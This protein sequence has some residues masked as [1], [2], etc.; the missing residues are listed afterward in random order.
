ME[1]MKLIFVA[2]K[3][4]LAYFISSAFTGLVRRMGAESG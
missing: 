3:E 2:R 1:L 4:L